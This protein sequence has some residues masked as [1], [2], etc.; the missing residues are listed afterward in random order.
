MVEHGSPVWTSGITKA[1]NNQIER[2]QKAAFAIILDLNYTSYAG[3][4]NY[5]DR[6]TLSERRQS[7]NV[8]FAKKALK[9]E[10]F[11]HWFCEITPTVQV[12]KTRSRSK[13]TNVLVPVEARTK[14]FKNSLIAYLTRLINDDI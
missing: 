5:L 3:A 11:N 14:G 7:I 10:K 4:L 2:V 1:E 12:P 13:N 8:K 9:S 6:T